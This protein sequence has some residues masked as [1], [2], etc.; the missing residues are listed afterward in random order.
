MQYI[1]CSWLCPWCAQTV[2]TFNSAEV[3]GLREH[4][5]GSSF[6]EIFDSHWWQ[7]D[8]LWKWI[9][10]AKNKTDLLIRYFG[11]RIPN[12]AVRGKNTGL[13]KGGQYILWFTCWYA[14]VPR[15]RVR[16]G[17]HWNSICVIKLVF[18]FFIL[19]LLW[20]QSAMF[21]ILQR[22]L[23]LRSY[24]ALSQWGHYANELSQCTVIF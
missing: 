2:E 5:W 20:F 24:N 22:R 3:L 19:F 4:D 6:R 14:I 1:F 8:S 13:C 21:I 11:G 18:S 10:R 23:S 16:Q 7:C 17:V 9:V 12:E 15:P